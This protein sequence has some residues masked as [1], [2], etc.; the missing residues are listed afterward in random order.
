MTNEIW[1]PLTE[2]KF[3]DGRV[4]DFSH[5]IEISN[6][7]NIRY[8]DTKKPYRIW[9]KQSSKTTENLYLCFRPTDINGVP[10]NYPR[11]HRAVA[12]MFV[13]GYEPGLEIDHID[14]D[15]LNNKASNL[16]WVTRSE[17]MKGQCKS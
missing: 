7:G 4:S 17:N 10:S 2:Y 9:K 11:V 5:L 1:K 3:Y 6:G 12:S 16:R 15:Y 14:D 13:P 8:I